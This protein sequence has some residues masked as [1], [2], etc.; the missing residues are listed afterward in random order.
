LIAQVRCFSSDEEIIDDLVPILWSLAQDVAPMASAIVSSDALKTLLGVLEQAKLPTDFA[1]AGHTLLRL[2]HLYAKST[3]PP[4][5]AL[6]ALPLSLARLH[7]AESSSNVQYVLSMT[8]LALESAGTDERALHALLQP[9]TIGLIARAVKPFS[10]EPHM[11]M[12]ICRLVLQL[13]TTPNPAFAVVVC[14]NGL[15]EPLFLVLMQPKA[16]GSELSLA[17]LR[18]LNA[19][20]SD[21]AAATIVLTWGGVAT[22]LNAL[23]AH[24][25]D[26][27]I[28]AIVL[29][30]LRSATAHKV[31]VKLLAE[32]GAVPVI[33]ELVSRLCADETVADAGLETLVA[34]AELP[35]LQPLLMTLDS[36]ECL[37]LV[38]EAHAV[39][40]GIVRRALSLLVVLLPLLFA[41][42][43]GD[44]AAPS[45][46]STL[47]PAHADGAPADGLSV[48]RSLL[49]LLIPLVTS[50]IKDTSIVLPAIE[51][52]LRVEYSSERLV[53]LMHSGVVHLL[54]QALAV[55][56][57][58][59]TVC[60]FALHL[61]VEMA[62]NGTDV[63]AAILAD[64][65]ERQLND[66][67][68]LRRA[69]DC[70][71]EYLPRLQAHPSAL[72]QPL[73]ALLP[74]FMGPGASFG[75]GTCPE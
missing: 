74:C 7:I 16:A 45:D 38:S 8:L 18:A 28:A 72:S 56:R 4:I 20:L 35:A 54:L 12:L 64:G 48:L 29:R 1:E 2:L 67:L 55:Y 50:H 42:I 52:L 46:G 57:T 71:L 17:S 36:V 3:P 33:L 15:L 41:R 47:I 14:E 51:A 69:A 66:L 58:S 68:L 30:M 27:P 61:L 49:R 21:A 43:Q 59:A 65:G 5:P 39:H 9:R 10:Q 34:I 60:L 25:E 24:R 37:R 11:A 63:V 62:E 6:E 19:L 53:E 22:F 73:P 31:G 26:V 32:K 40:I 75:S 23:A 13:A 70:A 44:G